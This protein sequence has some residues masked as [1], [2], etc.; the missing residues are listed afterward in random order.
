VFTHVYNTSD[1]LIVTLLKLPVQS[2]VYSGVASPIWIFDALHTLSSVFPVPEPMDL[3]TSEDSPVR[4]SED[5][6]VKRG[7]H[8]G[9]SYM[10]VNVIRVYLIILCSV[11]LLTISLV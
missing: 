6:P 4:T 7:L 9:R 8:T 1:G 11:F 5:S 2:C 3:E 10:Y